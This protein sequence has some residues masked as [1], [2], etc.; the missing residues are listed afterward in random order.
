MNESMSRMLIN[1]ASAHSVN[2]SD[3]LQIIFIRHVA[4]CLLQIHNV[5]KTSKGTESVKNFTRYIQLNK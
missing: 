4:R 3:Q 2:F 5:S 1:I